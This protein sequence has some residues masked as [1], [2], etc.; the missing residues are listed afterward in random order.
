VE[1]ANPHSQRDQRRRSS[2]RRERRW[3][4][5]DGA[6]GGWWIEHW[7]WDRHWLRDSRSPGSQR[8]SCTSS[9]SGGKEPEVGTITSTSM[10][11][12][13]FR[14]K[15]F[16]C[17]TEITDQSFDHYFSAYGVIN[18]PFFIVKKKLAV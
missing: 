15:S 4:E 7:K 9:C 10:Q 2:I 3:R 12:F 14:S 8:H 11:S 16:A 1:N 6:E 5:R 17:D 18:D 13:E